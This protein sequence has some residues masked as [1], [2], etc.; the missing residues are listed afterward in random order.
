MSTERLAICVIDNGSAILRN[1]TLQSLKDQKEQD[2]SCEVLD[3]T[4]F[5][6]PDRSALCSWADYVLFVYSGS[7]LE[8]NAVAA[9]QNAIDRTHAPW[10]YF[11]E[12]TY[13]K[14]INGEFLLK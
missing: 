6:N 13:G 14:E 10:L 3:C 5:W 2:F 1:R 9:L 8:E 7:R 12:R 11:D 4:A